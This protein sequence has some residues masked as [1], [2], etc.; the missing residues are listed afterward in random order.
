VSDLLAHAHRWEHRSCG[1][2]ALEER[3]YDWEFFTITLPDE[4]PADGFT[5]TLTIRRST[6]D[7][8]EVAYFLAHTPHTTGTNA[9]VAVAG[10]RWRIE[11]RNEHGNDLIGLDPHQVRT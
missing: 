1:H 6:S 8:T 3:V 9:M 2:A 7:P 10:T 4:P 11:E 5:H